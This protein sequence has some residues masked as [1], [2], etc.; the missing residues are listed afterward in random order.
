MLADVTPSSCVTGEQSSHAGPGMTQ[1]CVQCIH[2]WP[3]L[4][5]AAAALT[6]TGHNTA[7]LHA[8][9]S[10]SRFSSSAQCSARLNMVDTSV[11]T[12]PDLDT[13]SY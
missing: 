8:P 11:T 9:Q 4:A 3:G 1:L 13:D 2:T 7:Q 5:A 6:V 10:Q 12:D